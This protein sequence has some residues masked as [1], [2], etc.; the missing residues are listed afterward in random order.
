MLAPSPK[1]GRRWMLSAFGGLVLFGVGGALAM[2]Q[3]GYALPYRWLFLILLLP[4]SSAMIDSFRLAR[5]L[6]WQNVQPLSRAIAGA[7]FALIAIL[8]SLRLNT[9]LILPALIMALGV[10]TVVRAIVGKVI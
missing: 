3:L 7:V 1:G 9:G 10:A 4:A 5:A 2:D 6:G 8:M